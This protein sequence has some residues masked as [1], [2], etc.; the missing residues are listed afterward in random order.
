MGYVTLEN[1]E[2]VHTSALNA[3]TIIR[4]ETVKSEP[5]GGTIC[6]TQNYHWRSG[7]VDVVTTSYN[8]Y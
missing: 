4:I 5:S 8:T 7:K 6:I 1:G 3:D 2:T